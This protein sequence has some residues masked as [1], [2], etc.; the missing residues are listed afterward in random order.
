MATY[1]SITVSEKTRDHLQRARRELSFDLDTDLSLDQT[2]ARALKA[3]AA[4]GDIT[5]EEDDEP[6]EPAS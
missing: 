1:K 5:P 3:L 4:A 6:A 2:L